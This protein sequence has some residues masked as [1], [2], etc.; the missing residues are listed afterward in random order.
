M[1]HQSQLFCSRLLTLWA[2]T[3]LFSQLIQECLG[4]VGARRSPAAVAQ[5]PPSKSRTV[6]QHQLKG[7]QVS[8]LWNMRSVFWMVGVPWCGETRAVLI[9]TFPSLALCLVGAENSRNARVRQEFLLGVTAFFYGYKWKME[10][11]VR[12][13][14]SPCSVPAV[15]FNLAESVETNGTW[16]KQNQ[17]LDAN[18]TLL[19][20]RKFSFLRFDKGLPIYFE[21]CIKILVV[22]DGPAFNL[23]HVALCFQT[24]FNS[25]PSA[26]WGLCSKEWYHI[27]YSG[28]W[29]MTG[30]V[31]LWYYQEQCSLQKFNCSHT[32]GL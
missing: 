8:R 14:L 22:L 31:P 26:Y 32:P 3:P 21:T 17:C 2:Q 27:T 1:S 10:R 16:I 24:F 9:K 11:L 5:L 28:P 25:R 13:Q 12:L 30:G 6:C 15:R 19:N 7:T 18:W 23:N 29:G 4:A 20:C